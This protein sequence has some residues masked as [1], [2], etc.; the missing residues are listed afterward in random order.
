V[1]GTNYADGR[2]TAATNDAIAWVNAQGFATNAAGLDTTNLVYYLTAAQTTNLVVAGDTA[3]SNYTDQVGLAVSNA[4]GAA[5]GGHTNTTLAGGAHGG[6]LDTQY[7]TWKTNVATT[8]FLSAQWAPVYTNPSSTNVTLSPVNGWLQELT[9]TNATT[10]LNVADG[11]TNLTQ[12]FRLELIP[13]T[14]TVLWAAGIS[15]A[16]N[17]TIPFGVTTAI[18]CDRPKLRPFWWV[19]KLGGN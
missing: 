6:E 3:G 4:A 14:N 18:L 13:G 16:A 15:N 9:V 17:V 11:S 8:G 19:L 1:A 10:V 12:G 5:L 7:A 2:Y